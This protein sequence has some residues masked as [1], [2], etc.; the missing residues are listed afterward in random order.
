MGRTSVAVMRRKSLA[1]GLIAGLIGGLVGTA[2][3]MFAERIFPP[4]G[5]GEAGPPEL[6]VEGLAGHVSGHELTPAVSAAASKGIHWGFGGVAGAAYGAVAEYYPIATAK[7]GASFGLVLGSLTQDG[8]LPAMGLAAEPEGQTVRERGS[9]M[10][11]HIVYG[12]V[13]EKVRRLVRRLL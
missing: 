8:A 3:K 12:V 13:T 5:R 6:M 2:A 10:T 1:K 7:D 11:S 4:R 9:E